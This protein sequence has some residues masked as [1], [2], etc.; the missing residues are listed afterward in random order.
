MDFFDGHELGNISDYDDETLQNANQAFFLCEEE[1]NYKDAEPLLKITAEKGYSYSMPM[2]ASLLLQKNN[3]DRH[4]A[5]TACELLLLAAIRGETQ[6]REYFET[7]DKDA[8]CKIV[9]QLQQIQETS[10]FE[11]LRRKSISN[12]HDKIKI[13]IA[14][15]LLCDYITEKR[16]NKT[17]YDK[18]RNVI[19]D[20]EEG[21]EDIGDLTLDFFYDFCCYG[22]SIDVNLCKLNFPGTSD[23][24][25]AIAIPNAE[26]DSCKKVLDQY[27]IYFVDVESGSIEKRYDNYYG[28]ITDHFPQLEIAK[29]LSRETILQQI[30]VVK[31]L[32]NRSCRYY[33]RNP[34]QE[35]NL[36][37]L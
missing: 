28:F 36:E 12:V 34:P 7:V 5:L 1:Q 27:P 6:S 4:D 8:V 11:W 14:K 19:E 30:P 29:V 26:L 37:D 15:S 2:Y 31:Q 35:M 20:C 21:S 9:T 33:R 3:L 24:C 32:S 17:G 16:M 23:W 18:I 25:F 10:V 13:E 22:S